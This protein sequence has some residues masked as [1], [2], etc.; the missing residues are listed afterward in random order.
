MREKKNVRHKEKTN[1]LEW[2]KLNYM[3]C[4]EEEKYD[5]HGENKN[6]GHIGKI[7]TWKT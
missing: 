5:I 3:I 1:I 2:G 6:N 4:E 7:Q